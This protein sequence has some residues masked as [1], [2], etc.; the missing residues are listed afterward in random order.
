[1]IKMKSLQLY[2]EQARKHKYE[3]IPAEVPSEPTSTSMILEKARSQINI[4]QKTIDTPP[5]EKGRSA[6]WKLAKSF[7]RKVGSKLHLYKEKTK[8][9]LVKESE[10]IPEMKQEVQLR[11]ESSVSIVSDELNS[12]DLVE[13]LPPGITCEGKFVKQEEQKEEIRESTLQLGEVKEIEMADDSTHTQDENKESSGISVYNQNPE[14]ET[15]EKDVVVEEDIAN[16]DDIVDDEV[17]LHTEQTSFIAQT[18]IPDS[19]ADGQNDVVSE[20]GRPLDHDTNIE[21]SEMLTE[22][23]AKKAKV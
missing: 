4:K 17:V 6:F 11:R 7:Q 12:V 9:V 14:N 18:S 1:M 16:D 21:D 19:T 3:S 23:E 2:D 8:P 13:V 10:N 15:E 5:L 22:M 20:V